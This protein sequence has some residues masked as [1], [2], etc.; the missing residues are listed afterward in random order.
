MPARQLTLFLVGPGP[1][2]ALTFNGASVTAPVDILKLQ[3]LIE[4]SKRQFEF[5]ETAVAR[6]ECERRLTEITAADQAQP[7]SVCVRD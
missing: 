1:G 7:D 3:E 2:A 4:E 6:R 5:K